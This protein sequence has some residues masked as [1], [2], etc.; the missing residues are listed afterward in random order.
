MT[1]IQ[2]VILVSRSKCKFLCVKT[3]KCWILVFQLFKDTENYPFQNPFFN[4]TIQA[5]LQYKE[6]QVAT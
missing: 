1:I 3:L 2:V 5:T 6:N 4:L